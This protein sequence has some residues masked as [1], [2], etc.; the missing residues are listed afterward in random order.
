MVMVDERDTPVATI[1][2]CHFFISPAVDITI[3]QNHE[4]VMIWQHFAQES[5]GDPEGR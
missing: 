4:N 3:Q 5:T 2:M 1:S